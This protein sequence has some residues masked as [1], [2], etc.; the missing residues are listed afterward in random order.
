[1]CGSLQFA[2]CY[3]MY[4][5]ETCDSIVRLLK[6]CGELNHEFVLLTNSINFVLMKPKVAV[7]ITAECSVPCLQKPNVL[8]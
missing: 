5:N 3:M 1:V 6:V 4:R 7:L 8:P 2:A